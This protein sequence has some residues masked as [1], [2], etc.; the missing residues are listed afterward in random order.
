[1]R[2]TPPKVFEDDEVKIRILAGWMIA[3]GDHPAVAITGGKA[4]YWY[5]GTIKR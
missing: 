4:N 1:V 5:Q 3:T 2:A